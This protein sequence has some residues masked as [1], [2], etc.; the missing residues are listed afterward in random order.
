MITTGSVDDLVRHRPR[1]TPSST[2]TTPTS[3]DTD[4]V[5]NGMINPL[6]IGLITT[7]SVV[8]GVVGGGYGS[9]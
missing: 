1:S 4:T 3:F 9:S 5:I 7:G 2:P 8:V 6:M